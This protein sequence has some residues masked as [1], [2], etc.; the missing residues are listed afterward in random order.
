MN[1]T[2]SIIPL[3]VIKA[4]MTRPNGFQ[5]PHLEAFLTIAF[6]PFIWKKKIK[7]DKQNDRFP[8]DTCG[9]GNAARGALCTQINLVDPRRRLATTPSRHVRNRNKQSQCSCTH[10]VLQLGYF[11]YVHRRFPA[12]SAAVTRVNIFT[13]ST[14]L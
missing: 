7:C 14:R 12:S 3:I 4:K 11:L 6:L 13:A 10:C 2:V 9:V 1:E 5:L 8:R